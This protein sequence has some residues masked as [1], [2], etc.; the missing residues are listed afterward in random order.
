VS[1]LT[2]A[3]A[4]PQRDYRPSLA[5]L[6]FT[7]RSGEWADDV[8]ADGMV[9]D[10]ISALSLS[11]EI[12]VIAQSATIVYRKNVSDLRSIGQDLGVRYLLEGNVRRMGADLRVTA[13]LVEAA[14]GAILW[15]QKFDRPLTELADLQEQLVTEVAGN[16]GVQVQRAEMEQAL[17]KPGELT[18]WEAVMRS[19][20]SHGI[21][22]RSNYLAAIAEGR[23]AI[24]IAPNYALG[25]AALANNLANYFFLWQGGRDK[26]TGQQARDH[27][28]RALALDANDPV[29]LSWVALALGYIGFWNEALVHAQ[30]SLDLNPNVAITHYVLA[31]ACIRF[32]RSGDA[33]KHGEAALVLAPRGNLTYATLG[34]LAHAHFLEGRVEQ[35]L[36]TVDQSLRFNPSFI[37]TLKDR[38]IYCEKLGRHDEARD[39][40]RRL[41][42][43]DGTIPLE[44]IEAANTVSFL[45]PEAA[46]DMNETFRKVWLQTST[47]GS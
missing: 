35:A 7:N 29:V 17:Q 11:S 28:E 25:H 39:S 40:V 2:I 9:E 37:Y 46:A 30:R 10:L 34:F 36:Q 47:P 16:L 21:P 45:P 42:A 19:R 27:A 18:A 33:I 31:Q 8:F 23:K 24:S 20:F 15:T 38:A 41:Q 4:P 13:Q 6:P 5:I 12:K 14:N 22:T 3:V 32:N 26:V 1:G 44:D 43:L